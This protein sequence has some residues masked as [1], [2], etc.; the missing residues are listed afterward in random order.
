MRVKGDKLATVKGNECSEG[1]EV[2]E[3]VLISNDEVVPIH[4]AKHASK[5][6]MLL[7]W[8]LQCNDNKPNKPNYCCKYRICY[9]YV[10]ASVCV[11]VCQFDCCPVQL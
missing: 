7:L 11:C 6:S 1:G 5:G 9:V 2:F 10:Y 3:N 4:A 8:E